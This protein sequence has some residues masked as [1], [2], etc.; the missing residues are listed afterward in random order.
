MASEE[1][2]GSVGGARGSRNKGKTSE[3]IGWMFCV[4]LMENK[5]KIRYNFC[6]NEYW[7]SMTRLNTLPV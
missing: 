5:K 6:N 4:L 2:G 3:D 1:V 7:G